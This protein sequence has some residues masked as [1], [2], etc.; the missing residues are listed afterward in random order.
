[1][2][3]SSGLMKVAHKLTRE[4]KAKYPE[5]DYRFQLGICIKFLLK[6][7]KKEMKKIN[8][9]IKKFKI[10]LGEKTELK[11]LEFLKSLQQQK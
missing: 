8:D 10:E 9:L 4:I 7:G 3:M 11:E 2:K 5:V 6:G 1:M